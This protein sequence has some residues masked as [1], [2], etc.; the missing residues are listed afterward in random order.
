MQWLEVPLKRLYKH[1]LRKTLGPFLLHDLDVDQ[2]DV[3]IL[4]GT[5]TLTDVE[6]GPPRR[7]GRMPPRQL[8]T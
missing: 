2:L 1:V 6:V 3:Q 8:P 4:G 5:V 7:P